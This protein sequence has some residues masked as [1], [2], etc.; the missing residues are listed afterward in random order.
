MLHRQS[1]Y[2]MIQL[3]TICRSLRLTMLGLVCVFAFGADEHAGDW[4]GDYPPCDR[5]REVL[6]PEHLNLGVRFSTTDRE[7]AAAFARAMNFW[8]TILDLEWHQ[9]D[10]RDCSIQLVDGKTDLFRR[11]EVARAQIP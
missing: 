1:R 11:G 4:T 5:H 3:S 2:A 9:E 10:T 8:S 6:T 7:L